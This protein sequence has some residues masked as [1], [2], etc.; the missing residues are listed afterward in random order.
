MDS[1]GNEL[2]V[3]PST[4]SRRWVFTINNPTEEDLVSLGILMDKPTVLY[5]IFQLES[6]GS[7]TPH[8]QGYVRFANARKLSGLKKLSCFGR[9][10]LERARGSEE[11]NIRYCSKA[12]GQLRPPVT[13]GTPGLGQGAR[14]DV[15]RY[16]TLRSLCDIGG[17]LAVAEEEFGLFLRFHSGLSRYHTLN[18]QSAPRQHRT[19]LHVVLGSPGTGKTYWVNEQTL[20]LTTYW[21]E[22]N[23]NW[24]DGYRP[25]LHSTVV[26]DEFLGQTPLSSLNRLIGSVPASVRSKGSSHQ[27]RCEKL[28][29]ISNLRVGEWYRNLRTPL[30]SLYRRMDAVTVFTAR[31]AHYTATNMSEDHS[32]AQQNIID[33]CN[34]D[35]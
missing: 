30:D 26:I 31:G 21:K 16:E 35:F 12:E 28:Y 27:F 11:D 1:V 2:R 5:A 15:D 25:E 18:L 6:G 29:L 13:F 14:T 20:P 32:I 23:D 19:E 10:H 33:A 17:L 4:R 22:P 3:H 9:A 24:W 34:A 8:Y 7:G